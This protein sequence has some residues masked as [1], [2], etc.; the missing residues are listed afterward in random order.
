[1]KFDTVI[2]ASDFSGIR[3][4]AGWAEAIGHDGLWSIEAAHEP[5]MPLAIASTV[6][7]GVSLGTAIAVAFPRNPTVLAHTCWD[8]QANSKGRFILGLG[9]QVKGHNE[10][11]FGVPFVSPVKKLREMILA[12]RAIWDCWQTGNRLRFEGEF[13]RLSMMTP[14]FS[15]SKVAQP[16]IPV[17]VAGV[18]RRIAEMAG[19]VCDGFHVHPLNSP[20]FLLESLIPALEAGARRAGRSRTDLTLSTQ[21]LVATGD[22]TRAIAEQREEI[23]HQIGFYASTRTYA[24]VLDTH[25]WAELSGRL[26]AKAAAGDWGGL[27]REV[28][29]EM[30][31]EFCIS[32][33]PDE[34]GPK[35]RAR[36]HGLLDRL[37]L[38]FPYRPGQNDA[39]LKR[40]IADTRA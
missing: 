23:R 11:R 32:G 8:L 34:I 9:T 37:S 36:Y 17:Y 1:M 28:S 33:P 15:P 40:I 10:R 24:P 35:L 16:H 31:D 5:F 14:F 6:T 30:V 25:G 22:S 19:E 18:N 20:R 2:A 3:D 7:H 12:M 26:S 39:G 27:A 21:A 4:F 29:D 38:Y 13:Y